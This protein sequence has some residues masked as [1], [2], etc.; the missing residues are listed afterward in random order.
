MNLAS[1][2][3][4]RHESEVASR[5]DLLHARFKRDVEADDPR[6]AAILSSLGDLS[7]Q[8]VLD[9]GCGKGR[10][11][12]SLRSAGALVVGL[13]LSAAMLSEAH[14]LARVRASAR[15]LPFGDRSFDAVVAVEAFEHFASIDDVVT[16]I[17][18]VLRPG[19]RLAVIDKN[20]LSL[21]ARRPW[22]PN[23]A[24]KRLE[25]R[26]GLWMYPAGGPV[27]ERWFRPGSLKRRLARQ[28]KDV[29]VEYLLSRSERERPLFRALPPARLMTLWTASAPGGRA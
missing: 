26:R 29:R 6:L 9:L 24:V 13:D 18:R 1:D 7:G 22:L 21:N 20:L 15:R 3:K 12:A 16:E 27:R 5:F 8:R 28:F 23:L 14:G 25:E 19:G 17:A 11:A 4:T 10:F 2:A